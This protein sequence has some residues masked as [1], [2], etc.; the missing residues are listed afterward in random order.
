VPETIVI[1]SIVN[2]YVGY[3]LWMALSVISD[4]AKEQRIWMTIVGSVVIL[5]MPTLIQ[6]LFI[7][8]SNL[9]L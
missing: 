1:A 7:Y 3:L 8:I 9:T 2:L 4:L 5:I 6:R